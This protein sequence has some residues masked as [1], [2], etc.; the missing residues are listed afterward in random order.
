MCL[1]M[2][3]E[4]ALLADILSAGVYGGSDMSRKHSSKITLEAVSAQNRGDNA[5]HGLLKSVFPSARELESRYPYL[6]SKP[7]LLP[8][9]WTDRLINY[10]KE[11]ARSRANSP[12]ESIRIGN[13]RLE[14]L[15]K[16]GILD[17]K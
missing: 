11:L 3:Q 8:L 6:K 7:L 12:A 1:E 2:D 13:T 9:A 17:K 5:S 4:E 16:Y 15:R 10:Q 14:L